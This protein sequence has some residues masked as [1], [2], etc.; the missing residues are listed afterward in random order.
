MVC[1]ALGLKSQNRLHFCCLLF[2]WRVCGLFCIRLKSPE[3]SH[4]VASYSSGVLWFALHQV[5]IPRTV[6]FCCFLF[7]WRVVVGFALDGN[8]QNSY[9]LLLL[10]QWRVVVCFALGWKST[11]Q[12]HSVASYSKWR[13]CG[14]FCIRLKSQN[15][16]ILLLHIQV[17]CCGLLCI[18]L[19]SPEQYILVLLIQVACCGLF[20]ISLKSPEQLHSVASYSSSV[21]WFVL[22]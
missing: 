12:L 20:C 10:I 14:L 5:E 8:P 15:S 18:R 17:A 21:L 6:T 1:F 3:H 4:F 9:I 13:V 2:K 7:K 16:Y 19:K 11:E 22:H